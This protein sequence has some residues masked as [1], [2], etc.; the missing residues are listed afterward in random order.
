MGLP[1]FE[2]R[3]VPAPPEAF[4]VAP[5]KAPRNAKAAPLSQGRGPKGS[6][7]GRDPVGPRSEGPTP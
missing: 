5:L 3:Q 7:K 2:D 6:I 4:M 1:T